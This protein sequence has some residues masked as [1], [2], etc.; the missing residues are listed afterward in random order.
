M[1][2]K[3]RLG[4][5]IAI[6]ITAPALIAARMLPQ[7]GV[8]GLGGAHATFA[9]EKGTVTHATIMAIRPQELV[10]FTVQDAKGASRT[11]SLCDPITLTGLKTASANDLLPSVMLRAQADGKPFAY[12]YYRKAE[13]PTPSGFCLVGVDL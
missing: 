10:T 11:L 6:A 13:G 8:P 4:S 5:L 2:R 1:P 7:Q 9:I 3:L 12:V